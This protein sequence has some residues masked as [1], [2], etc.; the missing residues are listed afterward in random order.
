MVDEN[1][2]PIGETL[3]QIA[4]SL[5]GQMGSPE[6]DDLL[7]DIKSELKDANSKLTD[8]EQ[9]LKEIKTVLESP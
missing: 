2:I 3:Q 5:G 4:K 1:H 6:V 8:I 9:V 7:K